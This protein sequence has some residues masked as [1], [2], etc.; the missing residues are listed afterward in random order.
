MLFATTNCWLPG[1]NACLQFTTL[2]ASSSGAPGKVLER[3][4]AH[5]S[6]PY[7]QRWTSGVIESSMGQ[8]LAML[9]LHDEAEEHFRLAD[10]LFKDA[11]LDE[12]QRQ[13]E[14]T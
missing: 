1:S 8:V 6:Y 9:A 4:I 11:D 12:A 14:R 10:E 5:P 7:L 13:R 3:L 2:I